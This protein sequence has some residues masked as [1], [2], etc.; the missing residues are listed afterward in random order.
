MRIVTCS[1]CGTKFTDEETHCPGC[2]KVVVE[3]KTSPGTN[4]FLAVVD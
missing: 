3:I 4:D 2:N 1:D